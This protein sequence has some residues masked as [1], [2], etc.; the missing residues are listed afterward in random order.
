[1][2]NDTEGGSDTLTHP[3]VHPSIHQIF[4]EY[5][6]QAGTVLGAGNKAGNEINMTSAPHEFAI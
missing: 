6:L 3:S 2:Q 5:L 4:I 1:M